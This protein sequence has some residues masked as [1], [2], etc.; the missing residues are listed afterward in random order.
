MGCSSGTIVNRKS[1]IVNPKSKVDIVSFYESLHN[2]DPPHLK[3]P[4]LLALWYDAKGEWEKSHDLVSDL[5][6]KEAAL[7]HAYLHR[8]EGDQW[9]A[10]YWYNRAGT[11]R[12]DITLKEEWEE[13]V[14]KLIA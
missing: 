6:S 9:N 5:H 12:K 7:I 1:K 8:K 14:E 2:A 13:L 4:L 3:N 10:D 11:K